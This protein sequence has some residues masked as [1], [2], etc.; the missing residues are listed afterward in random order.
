MWP[1]DAASDRWV[2]GEDET[3]MRGLHLSDK[4]RYGYQIR[5]RE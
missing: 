2:D 5:V 1:V 3:E 4:R